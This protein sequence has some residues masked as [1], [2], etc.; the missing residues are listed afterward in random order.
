MANFFIGVS[1]T[2]LFELVGCGVLVLAVLVTRWSAR[3]K[4]RALQAQVSKLRK[5]VDYLQQCWE[6]ILMGTI[7]RNAQRST[8]PP[9]DPGSG[10]DMRQL[11]FDWSE[12]RAIMRADKERQRNRLKATS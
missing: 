12:R 10:T 5:D 8:P 4:S 11:S 7:N 1:T 3:R 6:R 9:L 2:Q